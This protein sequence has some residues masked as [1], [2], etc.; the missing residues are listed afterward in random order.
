MREKELVLKY[1]SGGEEYQW[2]EIENEEEGIDFYVSDL[3]ECPEDAVLG[4]DLFC[5]D[6]Y[7][8]ALEKGMELAR[9]G[10]TKIVF[11][12]SDKDEGEE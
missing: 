5:A 6:D 12:D 9:K 4:R 2:E 11:D 3:D 8:R 1:T 7:V 10:Y